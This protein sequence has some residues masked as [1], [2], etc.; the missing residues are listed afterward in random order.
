MKRHRFTSRK[1]LLSLSIQVAAILTLLWPEHEDQIVQAVQ[2][3]TALVVLLLGGL[4]YLASET[5]LDR[6]HQATED[7][8]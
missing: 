7:D 4:G 6:Q 1:F 3:V 8:A 2:S 5:V